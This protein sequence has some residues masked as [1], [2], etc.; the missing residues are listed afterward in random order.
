MCPDFCWG[1]FMKKNIMKK[2]NFI[3]GLL[4]TISSTV[5]AQNTFT[6]S[7][8]DLGGEATSIEEFNGFGCTGDNQSPQLSW[9]NAPE[10]T[11]DIIRR[12]TEFL[13][14][15][16]RSSTTCFSSNT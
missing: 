12:F 9:K 13:K 1:F 4:L 6:L 15:P 2:T 10:G 3:L 16:S 5:F 11:S 7:S 8:N 14:S